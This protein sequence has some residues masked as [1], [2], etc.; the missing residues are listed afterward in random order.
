M[1]VT[2][3]FAFMQLEN[4][5]SDKMSILNKFFPYVMKKWN[6]NFTSVAMF[7]FFF[8]LFL[9]FPK[10]SIKNHSFRWW[11]HK[12]PAGVSL[13]DNFIQCSMQTHKLTLQY[14]ECQQGTCVERMENFWQPWSL[15]LLAD[16]LCRSICQSWCCCVGVFGK[17]LHET[18]E[19]VFIDRLFSLVSKNCNMVGSDFDTKYSIKNKTG[20]IASAVLSCDWCC[21]S[22]HPQ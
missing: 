16:W 11:E 19:T 6:Q 20:L 18:Y 2:V 7:F 4:F 21:S 10:G 13:T 1:L 3:E 8:P 9:M 22:P 5:L 14:V 17:V 15:I 12:H